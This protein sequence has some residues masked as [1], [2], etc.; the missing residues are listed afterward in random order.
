ME[1]L[2]DILISISEKINGLNNKLDSI[3]AVSEEKEYNAIKNNIADLL[4][5]YTKITIFSNKIENALVDQS[6]EETRKKRFEIVKKYFS[7]NSDF[8]NLQNIAIYSAQQ[9]FGDFLD[10]N[11]IIEIYNIVYPK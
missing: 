7:S 9:Y 2:N 4:E 11:D 8:K 3:D 6:K 5:V 10:K 1:N